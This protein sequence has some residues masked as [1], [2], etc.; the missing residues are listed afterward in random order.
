MNSV[1]SV[2]E[3][4]WGYINYIVYEKF[5]MRYVNTHETLVISSQRTL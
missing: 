2:G 3:W 4:L 1:T 5:L